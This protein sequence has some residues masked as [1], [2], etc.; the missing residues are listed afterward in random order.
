MDLESIALAARWIREA[1]SVVALTG[2]GVSVESGLADFRSPGGLWTRYD[3]SVYCHIDGFRKHPEKVW[4]FI[5]ELLAS[6]E[7]VKPNPGHR[8][9]ARLEAAGFLRCVITQ[10]I[11]NLHQEGGSRDVVEFH[12]N[13]KALVCLV[14][15]HREAI[16]QGRAIETP[17]PRCACGQPLKPD[18]VFFGEAIPEE[19]SGKAFRVAGE[20]GV[21]LVAGTAAEV[22][23]ASWIPVTA[24]ESGARIVELNL[25]PTLLSGRVTD[26]FLEGPFGT[27]MPALAEAVLGEGGR[28]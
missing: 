28:N 20:A 10:N 27:I 3:P 22:A 7:G 6:A 21:L 16:T 23:P 18:F 13:M 25:H 17:Y 14:C 19:A 26:L 12:G 2:A 9:L 24:K 4:G 15:G 5:R 8:A 1:G 11:D